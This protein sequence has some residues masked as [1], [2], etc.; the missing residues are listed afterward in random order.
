MPNLHNVDHTHDASASTWVDA[1]ND[2]TDFPIQ[3]LPLGV[4]SPAGGPPRIGTAI[5]DSILD[6]A[7]LIGPDHV[8]HAVVTALSQP[9]LNVLFGLPADALIALRHAI[10]ALLSE[11]ERRAVV[12]PQLHMA[13]NCKLHLPFEVG[14]YTDFYTGIHHAMNIGKQ[15]RPDNPLLPNYKYIPIAYHGRASSLRASGEPV[16]RPKGQLKMV[17]TPAPQYEAS[18][19]LDYELELGVWVAGVNE[20]G[21]TVPI[22]AAATRIG[23]YCL[24]NDWSARDIQAWEY[25]P[26]GP[27]M[28]K[29]FLTS[30]SPWV[31]TREAM[32]PFHRP[33]RPRA[34]TDP[35]TLSHLYDSEDQ[36]KGALAITL[37]VSLRTASMRATDRPAHQLSEVGADWMY[38]TPAQM[39]AHHTSNGCNLQAGDLLG[40]GTISGPDRHSFGSLMELSAGGEGRISLPNG[41]E[42]AFLEDGD[43]VIFRAR[44][45]KDGYRSIGFGICTGT[46]IA[47][48]Q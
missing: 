40:T 39:I 1:A 32:A 25:Q 15:L 11:H 44:A 14:D 22:D 27:F 29:S 34:D 21:V 37:E 33:Q 43:E 10:F 9:T 26:L 41:E 42:R 28:A 7:A 3:N 4:F 12:E 20:L 2:H 6:L 48:R 46:V 24:L 36:A 16:V 18:R 8:P 19:R 31:V 30:V 13:A 45:E 5:G 17:G 35:A 47:C 38:W 23:G